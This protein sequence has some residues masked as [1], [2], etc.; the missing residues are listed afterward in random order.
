[1]KTNCPTLE[2]VKKLI[3]VKDKVLD[4][5]EGIDKKLLSIKYQ[6]EAYLT[7]QAI[8]KSQ[9]KL[10]RKDSFSSQVIRT[11]QPRDIYFDGEQYFFSY[12]VFIG[13]INLVKARTEFFN[14]YDLALD[15]LV[16]VQAMQIG[17]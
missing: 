10:K 7:K 6:R 14:N 3:G 5:R 16:Q 17:E 11:V 1:M 2:Q 4:R 9:K 12:C 15:R 8:I 13:S